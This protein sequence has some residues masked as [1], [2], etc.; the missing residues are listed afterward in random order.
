MEQSNAS[1]GYDEYPT[2]L[3]SCQRDDSTECSEGFWDPI[4]PTLPF[5]C[6]WVWVWLRVSGIAFIFFPFV[7]SSSSICFLFLS[8]ARL[9][10]LFFFLVHPTTAQHN[11]RFYH[12]RRRVLHQHNHHNNLPIIAG[13]LFTD[14][15]FITYDTRSVDHTTTTSTCQRQSFANLWFQPIIYF[16]LRL[17]F[18]PLGSRNRR[19]CAGKMGR[20]A[21]RRKRQD[22]G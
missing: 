16:D 9:L 22:A 5:S 3:C 7:S 6:V 1:N 2:G 19:A 21:S 8:F 12:P 14:D 15:M 4:A 18:I 20:E 10:S 17:S 11:S 13:V